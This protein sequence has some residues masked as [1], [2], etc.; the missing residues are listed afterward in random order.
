MTDRKLVYIASPYA[1][2]IK[3]NTQ[4]TIEYCRY[5]VGCGVVPLAPHLLLPKFL[6]EMNP[7]ERELGIRMGLQLLALCTELWVFGSRIT[8]GMDREISKAQ[9]L[10]IPVKYI[11]KLNERSE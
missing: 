6:C 4:M 2:D 9:R 1:G 5:A 3:Y 10:G 11:E 8:E 7:E